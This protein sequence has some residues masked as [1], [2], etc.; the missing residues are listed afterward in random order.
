VVKSL[1]VVKVV[2]IVVANLDL[3]RT[4]AKIILTQSH[5][6]QPLVNVSDTKRRAKSGLS[7]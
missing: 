3:P 1:L 7:R 2:A 5:E 6:L 4:M